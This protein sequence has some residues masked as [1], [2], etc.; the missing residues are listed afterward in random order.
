MVVVV[1]FVAMNVVAAFHAYKFTHFAAG[2]RKKTSSPEKLSLGDKLGA[3]VFGISNPRPVN[4]KAP[5]QP[6]ETIRL[7][8]NKKIECWYIRC[9]DS[10]PAKGTVA[11]FHGYSG[12]KSSMLDKSDEFLRMGY[13]TLLVDLMGSGGSEGDQTTL[14]YM[15]AAQVRT[16]YEYLQ[17]RGEQ[18]I[19]LFGT[20]MG[21]AAILRAASIYDMRPASLILECPFGSMYK[22]TSARFRIMGIPPLPMAGLLVF[23]GGVLNGFNAMGH[24]PSTYAANVHSP[25]LLLYGA[26]DLNVSREETDQIFAGL[27]GPKTLQI[28][29]T[30]GHENYLIK[31]HDDWV[32]DV[33]AFL[34]QH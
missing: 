20:S 22:T 31:Y 6:Y 9:N 24:N 28:Y 18:H 3:M 32:R 4:D 33:A 34:Q 14:G 8:S 2:A 1:A 10:V 30:A 26:C 16:A 11:I 21:A 27:K 15:E 17:Q 25:T 29:P 7:K 23:W 12:E 19:Y 5:T 13:N